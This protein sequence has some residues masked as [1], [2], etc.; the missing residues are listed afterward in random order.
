MLAIS[1][2]SSHLSRR[3]RLVCEQTVLFVQ[4]NTGMHAFTCIRGQ[5]NFSCISYIEKDMRSLTFLWVTPRAPK[6]LLAVDEDIE[7]C[8]KTQ[9]PC[10]AS[11]ER[12]SI[13]RS[14]RYHA[15]SH[16]DMLRPCRSTTAVEAAE[17]MHLKALLFD[18]DGKQALETC[19]CIAEPSLSGSSK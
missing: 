12:A 4:S 6:L 17:Q 11:S 19:H 7:D 16:Q 1:V 5:W 8:H 18:C 3:S 9:Y 2:Q 13:P 14:R 15:K 10:R